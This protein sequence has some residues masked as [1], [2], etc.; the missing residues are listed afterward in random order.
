MK[1]LDSIFELFSALA[2]K[3]VKFYQK[4]ISPL[5]PPSCR[6]YPTCS[7]YALTLLRFDNIFFACIKICFR[8]L[9]CNQFFSGGYSPPFVFL[10][11]KKINMFKKYMYSQKHFLS[12][13]VIQKPQK[14]AY[15]FVNADSK[16]IKLQKFYII[17]IHLI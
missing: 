2:I 9:S 10:S 14:H 17:S 3:L 8:I 16:L 1:F 15:F 6:Y 11:Q 4:F 7:S 5:T 12:K 13:P